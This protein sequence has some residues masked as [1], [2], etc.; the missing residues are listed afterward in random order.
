[1]KKFALGLVL[2][3]F[4]FSLLGCQSVNLSNEDSPVDPGDVHYPLTLK[5][6]AGNDVTISKIPERIVSLVPSDTEILFAIGAGKKVVGVTTNDDYPKEVKNLPKV[7]DMTINAEKVV[8]LKP[9][10]IF[11]SAL[12]GKETIDKLKK[13]GLT[14]FV[15][16]ANSI[17]GVYQ[18]IDLAGQIT[19]QLHQ[20]DQ[21]I[22]NMEAEKLQVFREVAKAKKDRPVKVWLE[23]DPSLYTAGKGTL[24]NELVTIAGGDNV[25][26]NLNGWPQVS[27]EQVVTWNPDVIVSMYGDT[28]TIRNRAGW[29]T[30]NAVKEKKITAIDPDI[31]SRPGPRI[32]EALHQLAKTFYPGQVK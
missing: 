32:I 16:D 25:A 28:S 21:L 31:V 19:N 14:V 17:K 23:S 20:S 27:S 13:L 30:I 5:D 22:G 2:L 29:N 26:K 24:L 15:L 7:G 1:M 8:A 18:S 3:L 4:V 12:N 6:Q 11:A 9:D 10:I